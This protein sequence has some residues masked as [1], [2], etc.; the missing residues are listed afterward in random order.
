MLPWNTL[1]NTVQNVRIDVC[2]VGAEARY[3][4]MAV[5]D[6]IFTSAVRVCFNGNISLL[7]ASQYNIAK[8]YL[9]NIFCHIILYANSKRKP[10]HTHVHNFF[11]TRMC[12]Y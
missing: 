8:R 1:L 6:N 5:P 2:S 11:F 12:V 10:Y 9:Y 7:K 4:P 3:I